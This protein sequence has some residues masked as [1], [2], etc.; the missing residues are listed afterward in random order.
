LGIGDITMFSNLSMLKKNILILS[1]AALGS[2]LVGATGILNILSLRDAENTIQIR[3][4]SLIVAAAT[5]A[6]IILC[7]VLGVCMGRHLSVLLKKMSSTAGELTAGNL[8]VEVNLESRDELGMLAESMRR[9]IAGTREQVRVVQ[10]VAEGDLTADVSIRSEH[11]MLGE[12]IQSLINHLHK[13]IVSIAAAANQ[14]AAGA[15][16]LSDSSMALS[17]GA[18]EQASSVEELT[19]SVEEI[20]SHTNLNAQNAETANE[21]ARNAKINAD[22]GNAQMKEMLKAMD[23]INVSS[24]NINKIIKVID[25]IAFQTN[26]LALNAAVEAARAGQ[27]GKGFAV[28]A[29]EVRTLAARSA[30]AVR[31]TTELIEGSIKKVEAGTKIAKDTAKA[32][33]QIVDLVEKAAGL[34]GSIAVA[35]R[36]QAVGIEQINQG[37]MQVSQ[38]VQTNA[39]TSE[40]SAAASQNLTSQAAQLKKLVG[41]FKLEKTKIKLD[42]DDPGDAQLPLA[43]PEGNTMRDNADAARVSIALSDSEFGKY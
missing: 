3:T 42:D 40:E 12:G 17:Q 18:T 16:I 21:L 25:D 13:M 38:V 29:E 30:N 4:A 6:V 31:E 34:V 15:A 22:N 24:G 2:V 37:I 10:M 36:E 33:V 1:T 23:E 19:A 9:L 28:V 41:L 5:A 11:D 43:E 26:I 27:H 35:S 7:I 32:L 39:A 8:N 14:V 20:A